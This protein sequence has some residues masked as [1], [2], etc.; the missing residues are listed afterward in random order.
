MHPQCRADSLSDVCVRNTL[1]DGE[2]EIFI[3]HIA[4]P[5]ITPHSVKETKPT[6]GSDD[7]RGSLLYLYQ[8][9]MFVICE[10][11][12][13]LRYYMESGSDTATTMRTCAFAVNFVHASHTAHHIHHLRTGTWHRDSLWRSAERCK[14]RP[15][16]I[17]QAA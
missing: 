16:R 8:C 17:R 13:F 2:Y 7:D 15:S 14:L 4:P 5:P 3:R 6:P 1:F 12:G 11:H 9:Q 10:C